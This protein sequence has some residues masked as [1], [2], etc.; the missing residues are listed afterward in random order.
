VRKLRIGLYPLSRDLSHPADRRRIVSW[1]RSRKHEL[2]INESK[3][4]DLLFISEGSDFLK[5]S[6][7]T[8]P[9]KIFDLIDGYLS[10]QDPKVD[11]SRGISKSIL[12][13][14][15]TYPR[16]F[17][18]MVRKTC[19]Q[20]DMVVCSSPEQ[21][22]TIFPYNSNVRIILD[23]HSEFPLLNFKKKSLSPLSIFWEGTTH[24][25]QGLEKLLKAIEI[26]DVRVNIVTDPEH[27]RLMGKYRKED[28]ERR[29]SS[30]IDNY[31]YQFTRWT[32][33][34][35]VSISNSSN[36]A[37]LPVD[38]TDKLQLLK[39][40]N[41]LLIMFRLGLPCLTSALASYKRI[42][43]ILETKITCET[44]EEWST[45]IHAFRENPEI[46]E[47]QVSRGQKYILENH[48]E[49]ILHQ[50][51]DDAVESLL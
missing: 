12:R 1:A 29:L 2:I 6:N 23:N 48:T 31:L 41:R 17:S 46:L 4:A 44:Y 26:E 28:V 37:V 47:H 13:Q 40:E 5:L 20:V 50:K 9:P 51:W 7:L 8:G 3:N 18:S 22:E 21:S 38:T 35:V 10:P 45:S 30:T 11:I 34:N 16:S 19:R 24:T 15:K 25:L 39:P 33:D 27:F 14:H 32:V 36:L 42:E 49:E 43:D